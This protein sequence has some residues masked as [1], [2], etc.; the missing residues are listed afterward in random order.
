MEITDRMA[1]QMEDERKGEEVQEGKQKDLSLAGTSYAAIHPGDVSPGG[2]V[3]APPT[4]E[5]KEP[6]DKRAQMMAQ[7]K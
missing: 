4:E 6:G 7:L 3:I 1:K 5:V 2:M